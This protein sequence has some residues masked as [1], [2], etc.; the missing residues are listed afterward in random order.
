[1]VSKGDSNNCGPLMLN[2]ARNILLFSLAL[3][4]SDGANQQMIWNI[5]YHFYLDEESLRVLSE[6]ARKLVS[7]ST[8]M[9]AWYS[10]TYG[11]ILRFCDSSTFTRVRALWKSYGMQDLEKEE[12]SA[13]N[14]ALEANIQRAKAVKAYYV[15]DGHVA[16]GTR[17]AAP[18]GIEFTPIAHQAYQHYWDHGSTSLEP[19]VLKKTVHPNPLFA[20][21]G[22]DVSTLH[23]GTDPLLGFHL[24]TAFAPLANGS[25]LAPGMSDKS[26]FG[27]VVEAARLQFQAW[28]KSFRLSSAK[29]L[30]I[31]FFS[32]DA[33]AF[34][35]ALS[36]TGMTEDNQFTNIYRTAYHLEPI[37][38]DDEDYGSAKKA[39]QSFT[40][41]DT[42]NLI[43]HLGALNL[44]SATS[45][46]LKNDASSSLYTDSLVKR[47]SNYRAYIED[48][49]CG[50]FPTISLLLELFPVE[51]WTNASSSST[52]DEAMFDTVV[53]LVDA[54]KDGQMRVRLTWKSSILLQNGNVVTT[55]RK[56]RFDDID[57]AYILYKVYQNMFQH[58]NMASLLS[59][60]DTLNVKKNSMVH[61]HRGS[62]AIF[63]RLVQS[64]VIVDWH[65]LMAKTLQLIET[66]STI[67]MGL[68]FIQELYLYLHTLNVYS[69]KTFS[70]N[71]V[72][73]VPDA[74]GISRW[75]GYPE[76]VCITL[77]VPR[78]A[79]TALTSPNPTDIGTPIAQCSVQ[80]SSRIKVGA[81]QNIFSAVQ[82]VF[83]KIATSG[84]RN[85]NNFTV[86]VTEDGMR[87]KGNSSLIVSFNVPSW[88]LLLEPRTA[89]VSFGLQ[90]TPYSISKFKQSLGLEMKVYETTL[91]NEKE[92][93]VTRYPPNVTGIA[94]VH[95][96]NGSEHKPRK[97]SY[98]EIEVAMTANVMQSNGRITSLIG[99]I[100]LV[101]DTLKEILRSG[102]VVKSAQTA[103]CEFTVS[104]KGEKTRISLQFPAPIAGNESKTR[105]ARKSSYVEVEAP[106]NANAWITFPAFISSLIRDKTTTVLSNMHGLN[107]DVLPVLDTTRHSQL[108]W[109]ITH[110]SGMFSARER[111]IREQPTSAK[112][113]S[114]ADARVSF[115]DSLFSLFM[116][117][118]GLQG[119]QSRVFGLNHPTAGGIHILIFASCLRLDIGSQTVVLDTAV[120][121]LTKSL[122]PRIERFLAAITNRGLCSIKVDDE[123]LK[124]WRQVLPLF[125]E[126]CRS[127]RHRS[128][129]NY[130]GVTSQSVGDSNDVFCSCGRGVL[131]ERFMTDIPLWSDVARY[132]T[133]VAISPIF[134]VP[135]VDPPFDGNSTSRPIPSDGCR[136]CGKVKAVNGGSLLKCG[137][138]HDAKYCSSDCQRADWKYHKG[139]CGKQKGS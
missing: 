27:N 91:S 67:M 7:L 78:Q 34:A 113:D 30:T 21:N 28:C 59:G 90:S 45:P 65:K 106:I 99:R 100:N 51:Y 39:P 126:R 44:L 94:L 62:F 22:S 43:D 73:R 103:P 42:S 80:S 29:A 64:R 20:Y 114:K 76:V 77:K 16:T 66:D 6:Q 8:S 95:G 86:Q 116:H 131:P 47:E 96:F 138:C 135:V 93:Y 33:I 128:S 88:F 89:N 119:Q 72:V 97:P 54:K 10:T 15:G 26:P 5:Y 134:S 9:R 117:F 69:A 23:Y 24:A 55:E 40:V 32:G 31:R 56:L 41:I 11:H 50:D 60:L 75:E 53:R 92:V 37:K 13:F 17:S 3:D 4:D 2:P 71:N 79:L 87:W 108:Q 74:S 19:S 98:Q 112:S 61:Y 58:E 82:I 115:K 125:A 123:E 136:K 120:L 139:S 124:L 12:R 18:I 107:M 83:G 109:L 137:A 101:S 49:L 48:L 85:S 36:H 35:H 84:T 122:I 57:L 68:N 133:R 111:R 121:P 46:L 52:A 118:T 129:C 38:L 102:C 127:W 25:P 70:Q 1:M 81:W 104:L 14:R 130:A 132:T 63:L 110:A 105:I